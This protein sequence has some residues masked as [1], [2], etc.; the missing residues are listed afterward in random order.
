MTAKFFGVGVGPGNPELLTLKAHRVLKEAN[1]LCV[2]VTGAEKESLALKITAQ[3]IRPDQE[4][5]ELHLPMTQDLVT[6][7]ECWQAA[8]NQIISHLR[9]GKRVAFLTI[10]DPSLFS[11]YTYI[12]YRVQAQTPEIPVE[13]IP[14]ITS[15]A[16]AAARL[17]QPL[18]EGEE[19][20]MIVPALKNPEELKEI[21][22]VSANVVLMKVSRQFPEIVRVLEETGHL[23]EAVL[24]TRCG[25]TGERIMWNLREALGEKIDYMSLIIIKKGA[26]R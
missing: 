1:L 8:A 4:I 10:G 11:T 5:L 9:L 2:P 14:G 17:N 6:L 3:Y 19:K 12:M 26:A 13:T 16:A 25:Q 24:V 20:L 22:K 23:K 15:L 18:S 7:E 21:F